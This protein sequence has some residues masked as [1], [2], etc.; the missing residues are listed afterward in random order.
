MKLHVS[1]SI[2]LASETVIRFN[3]S[4]RIELAFLV[5]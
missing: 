1:D 5:Q 3:P 4:Q 2:S